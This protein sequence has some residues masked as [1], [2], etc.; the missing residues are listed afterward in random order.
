MGLVVFAGMRVAMHPPVRAADAPVIYARQIAPI[1]YK[2]CTTCHHPGG[3]G[4][5]SLMT[6]A[7]ARRWGQQMLQV[8]QSRYMPPWLPEPGYGDFADNRRLSDSDLKLI[9]EWVM[10]GMAQ[11]DAAD[12]P[13]APHYGETWELGPPDLILKVAKPYTLIASGTDVFRNFVLPYPLKHTR[14]VRAIEILPGTPQ[15]VHHANVLIDRTA[16]FRKAHPRD[17]QEGVAGMELEVDAG[18]TFDPDSHFLFWK[19]D[20]PVLTEP[21]GMPWR[22]DPGND[23]ILNMHLKPSGKLETMQAEIGLYFTD[24]PP[25]KQPMLLQLEDDRALDIPP[26]ARDFVVQDQMKLPVDVEVLGVYPHAHYLGKD[27][28]GYAVLPSGEKK[29]LVWIRNWDIDRQSVYRYRTPLRLPKGTVL[30]MRYTYDNS[31]ENIH[32]PNNPPIRVKAG[33]RSVDEMGHLWLQVLPLKRAP[34]APDPRYLLEQAWMENRLRKDPQDSI[35][36]FNLAGAYLGQGKYSQAIGAYRRELA[37][38][39]DNPRT[40]TALGVA[41]DKAGETQQAAETYEKAI[42]INSDQVDARFD[43]GRMDLNHDDA[44]RAEQQFRAILEQHSDDADAHSGL[45]LALL[46]EQRPDAAQPE[47]QRAL[48]LN[49]HD[50]AA[51]DG[52]AQL[53]IAS[54][55]PAHAADL[56]ESAVKQDDKDAEMREHLAM[57][58]VQLGRFGDAAT[59]LK[60]AAALTPDDPTVHSLLSQVLTTTGQL[61]DA[62]VEQQAALH[63]DGNDADGWNNL[64]V[65]EV[66]AGKTS[67]AR[68][69]FQHALRIA[70]NHAQAQAN[71]ARLQAATTGNH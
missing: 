38:D 56:L 27:L 58:Y 3:A 64:G 57:A 47:F 51:L 29:W 63:L 8:T 14:Y 66:K 49:P 22:L 2:N 68:E 25:E 18:H 37:I 40:L 52:S 12:V 34:D 65:L 62:I 19:P 44:A 61:N 41:L 16:S 59:Q 15:V 69:D 39:A 6:Y 5:F 7:D 21:E 1:L 9:R 45:G 35:A 13:A 55:D 32:N 70:P 53:A 23:L 43:L 54:G 48:E 36:I 24:K 60:A 50:A 20:T 17:W 4:P 28:Q 26:G 42:D 33:N 30:Y 67:E 11:G 10:T 71:L 46:K 31:S